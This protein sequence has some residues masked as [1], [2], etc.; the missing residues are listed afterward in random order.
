M[1]APIAIG[2]TPKNCREVLRVSLDRWQGRPTCDM[3]AFVPLSSSSGVLAPTKKGLT[4]SPSILPQLIS[5]LTSAYERA[6]AEG[7]IVEVGDA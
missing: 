3:R 4:V 2:E 5:L 1:R 6:K 7:M